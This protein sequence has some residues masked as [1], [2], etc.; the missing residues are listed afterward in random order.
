VL[1]LAAP[2]LSC[3]ELDPP[4]AT[5]VPGAEGAALSG[6]ETGRLMSPWISVG[7]KARL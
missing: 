5:N 1:S 3:A 4:A 2:Q 6:F 7:V